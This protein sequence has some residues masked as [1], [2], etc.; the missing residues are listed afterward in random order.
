MTSDDS[1]PRPRQRAA[2]PQR[3]ALPPPDPGAAGEAPDNAPP[4]AGSGS[5]AGA[6]SPA[7]TKPPS[8]ARAPAKAP[9]PAGSRSPA[10]V[11]PP[12]GVKQ[13]A[14]SEAEGEPTAKPRASAAAE[15]PAK[16]VTG[17]R[18]DVPATVEA[19]ETLPVPVE[20][21]R[22]PARLRDTA[23]A[24]LSRLRDTLEDGMRKGMSRKRT[25]TPPDA[26]PASTGRAKPLPSSRA[27]A[28]AQQPPARSTA[29]PPALPAPAGGSGPSAPLISGSGSFGGAA[30]K[31]PILRTGRARMSSSRAALLSMTSQ[32]APLSEKPEERDVLEIV[33]AVLMRVIGLLWLAGAVLVWSRLIGYGE[34][35]PAMYWYDLGHAF[36]PT[37]VAALLAPIVG[38]GL[39]LVSRWGGVVWAAAVFLGLY[40]MLAGHATPPFDGVPLVANLVAL[41]VLGSIAGVRAWHDY[42]HDR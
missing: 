24:G 30:R 10:E 9:A 41:A 1:E 27:P 20:P 23:A 29:Q 25:A 19:H 5:Q 13:S 34:G 3:A 28:L 7:R 40:A 26:G 14:K 6:S 33:E 35:A 32:E 2:P 39:W 37:L 18:A 12:A 22:P 15:P 8:G 16:A 42:K 11:P 17:K 21:P 38:V 4:A 36:V 31:R